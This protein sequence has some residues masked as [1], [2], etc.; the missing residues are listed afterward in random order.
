M[1]WVRKA[2]VLTSVATHGILWVIWFGSGRRARSND[3]SYMFQCIHDLGSMV[4]GGG[5]GYAVGRRE[6]ALQVCLHILIDRFTSWYSCLS[7]STQTEFVYC[8]HLN[9]LIAFAWMIWYGFYNFYLLPPLIFLIRIFLSFLLVALIVRGV[10]VVRKG[11][12]YGGGLVDEWGILSPT[13]IKRSFPAKLCI[14]SLGSFRPLMRSMY[15]SRTM[16][17]VE[18]FNRLHTDLQDFSHRGSSQITPSTPHHRCTSHRQGH[19]VSSICARSSR[20]YLFKLPYNVFANPVTTLVQRYGSRL[21]S[22]SARSMYR[23]H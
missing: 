6:F 17:H 23:R 5:G 7:H 2:M 16:L 20:G 18:L 21:D 19:I 22:F 3:D 11:E 1:F 13:A 10:V 4:S 15:S 12:G 14:S 9:A 8:G